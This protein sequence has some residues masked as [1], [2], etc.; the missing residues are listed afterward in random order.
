LGGLPAR[1]GDPIKIAVAAIRFVRIIPEPP[2]CLSSAL[3]Y[4]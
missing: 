2:L 1:A 3:D 4:E